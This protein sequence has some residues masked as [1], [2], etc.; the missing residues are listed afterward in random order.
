MRDNQPHILLYSTLSCLGNFTSTPYSLAIVLFLILIISAAHPCIRFFGIFSVILLPH[1]RLLS[2]LV[3]A[4][5]AQKL[6]SPQCNKI[7]SYF[8]FYNYGALNINAFITEILCARLSNLR[9]SFLGSNINQQ[10]LKELLTA[11]LMARQ[12]LSHLYEKTC[13]LH[14]LLLPFPALGLHFSYS[15]RCRADFQTHH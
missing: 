6:S 8:S 7:S 1:H 15:V 9:T 5:P 11:F 14:V 2:V 13:P 3:F 4:Y 12:F 10:K